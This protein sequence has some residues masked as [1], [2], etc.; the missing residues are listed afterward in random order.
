M[1]NES[2]HVQGPLQKMTIV[3]KVNFEARPERETGTIR[4][5]TL[6]NRYRAQQPLPLP[7][8]VDDS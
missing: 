4:V 7:S 8:T 1:K 2:P 6:A 5:S 3:Q